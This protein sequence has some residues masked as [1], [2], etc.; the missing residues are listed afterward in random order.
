MY[1][2]FIALTPGFYGHWSSG[3]TQEE[4]IKKLKVRLRKARWK[5]R[6]LPSVVLFTSL[7][8]FA[9]VGRAATA[10]ESAAYIDSHGGVC[11][12]R[13]DREWITSKKKS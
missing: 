6:A 9:P 8:P 12:L 2:R 11:S 13:A 5:G 10:T 4:A 1:F 3:E 7:L